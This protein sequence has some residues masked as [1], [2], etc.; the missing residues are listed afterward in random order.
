MRSVN[1][2]AQVCNYLAGLGLTPQRFERVT[3]RDHKTPDFRILN[4]GVLAF[5]CE[6]KTI[7]P[8]LWL[9]RQ[10]E[11]ADAG[12]LVG[13]T[14]NDPIFNRLT[15]HIERAVTQFDAVNP[16]I[17][18]PN[19]LCF[20]NHDKLCSV[21][22]LHSV[23][24]GRFFAED[25]SRDPIYKKFSDGRIKDAIPRIHLF[26]WWQFGKGPHM[27]FTQVDPDKHLALCRLLRVNPDD[28]KTI[29]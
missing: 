3:R 23:V 20:A 14:R 25:G 16:D 11:D 18:V 5:Y 22:D 28:V 9:D 1:D 13:G 27:A 24:T 29:T 19:V 10:L 4:D 7:E 12:E 6:V 17:K 21:G 15:A 26:C 8:D 2:E